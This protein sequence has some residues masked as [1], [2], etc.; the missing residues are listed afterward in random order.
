MS[1]SSRITSSICLLVCC[2]LVTVATAQDLAPPDVE[3]SKYQFVGVVNSNAVFVRSGPS[4]NDYATI[5]L[6]KGAQVK[7]VGIRFEWLKVVP[8][9]GS[10]CYVAKA[11]VDRRGDGGVGRVTNT[12]NVRVGSQLNELKAK[13]A[14][15]LEPGA[16]VEILGEEQ[17]YFKIRP[18]AGVFF[19]INKQYVDPSH[20]IQLNTDGNAVQ[21][22]TTGATDQPPMVT[23]NPTELQPAPVTD[24]APAADAPPSVNPT[25]STPESSVAVAKT[26]AQPATQPTSAE[27]EFDRLEGEYAQSSLKPLEEQ[28]VQELMEQYQKLASSAELPESLRRIAE[29]KAS[30]L[31]TRVD[32]KAQLM[33]VRAKQDD[34]RQKQMALRAEKE[35]LEQRVKETEI[36]FYTAVGTLRPSSLQQNKQATLYR[37][38]DPASGRTVVYVRSDDNELAAMIGQFIGVKGVVT[39]D[40]QLNMKI[41]APE[42]YE[43][44]NP[45]KVGTNVAAQIVPPSL[46]PSV[47]VNT[48]PNE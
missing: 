43:P 41:I 29:F 7:V 26:D 42:S 48:N 3:N 34:M 22:E 17:E 44:V 1:A 33:E 5:K 31:Q 20:A 21:P 8:P 25:D 12:L 32:A 16:D 15:K 14:T 10:F 47:Q 4:E 11:F 39:A 30:V 38:T 40:E 6:D 46:L 2:L 9:E 23:Q 18:P 24:S 37:L 27:A 13:I 35:E 28:P 45:S 36:R 19:Y